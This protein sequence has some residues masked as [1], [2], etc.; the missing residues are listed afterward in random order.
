MPLHHYSNKVRYKCRLCLEGKRES[1]YKPK[2][3]ALDVF[4]QKLPD[5]IQFLEKI[6]NEKT[7]VYIDYGNVRGW[8]RR[9]GWKIDIRKL[10]DFF[11]SFGILETRFYFGTYHGD[12]R[13]EAFMKMVHSCGYKVRTK[14][15]KLI[16]VSI[17]VTSVSNGS[18]AILT[19]FIDG[20]LLKNLRVD[21]IEYLNDELRN[22]NKSGKTFLESS[23]CNFDVEIASDM[24][25]DH[26]IQRAENFCLVSGDSDFADPLTE[27]LDGQRK[28]CVI[29]TVR[30][31]ASELNALQSRGLKIMDIKKLKEFIEKKA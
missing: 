27:L 5:R 14:R 16:K 23:K 15:V 28:V 3:I 21:A 22:M 7:V 6:L 20:I 4:G 30:H 24:R 13:S 18:P 19:N 25:L 17:D 31:I 10:K 8:E 26:H 9:L 11:D 1:M 29:G 12:S 2:T